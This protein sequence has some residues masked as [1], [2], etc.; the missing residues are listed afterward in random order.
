MKK[1][2]AAPRET[3]SP[4]LR[5][6]R[7]AEVLAY[8]TLAEQ[9]CRRIQAMWRYTEVAASPDTAEDCL[10]IARLSVWQ[11]RPHLDRL[12]DAE[13]RQAYAVVCAR[14]EVVRFLRRERARHAR[15][16][17]LECLQARDGAIACSP[18]ASEPAPSPEAWLS[19]FEDADLYQQVHGLPERDRAILHLYYALCM[20]DDKVARH[21]DCSPSAVARQRHRLLERL[22]RRLQRT[23]PA[24][25]GNNSL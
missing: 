1:S 19:D 24:P 23:A 10:Q 16:T 17:S 7:N 13:E 4:P 22:R 2:V 18:P 5:S 21:L 9:V 14:R 11:A 8:S 25:P 20:T 15:T 12:P 6:R 3:P